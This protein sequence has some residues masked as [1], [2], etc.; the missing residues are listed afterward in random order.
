MRIISKFKDYY[1]SCTALGFDKSLVWVREQQTCPANNTF[2]KELPY[3]S[4]YGFTAGTAT[5]GIHVGLSSKIVLF[6]GKL[7]PCIIA[8]EL[9]PGK[10]TQGA[11]R[12]VFFCVDSFAAYVEKFGKNMSHVVRSR[13]WDE[14][15]FKGTEGL[16]RWFDILPQHEKK[17]LDWSINNRV[18]CAVYPHREEGALPHSEALIQ[19]NPTLKYLEFFKAYPPTSAFQEV[20]MFVGGVLPKSTAMPI[21]ISDKD[22]IAQHG[23]DKHSFRKQKGA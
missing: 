2:F 20:S 8:T 4:L 15:H 18:V 16:R 3:P 22:R 23:F 17:A 9:E 13:F 21:Q 19:L 10:V 12:K 14:E 7:V 1:D 6:C 11:I 5:G